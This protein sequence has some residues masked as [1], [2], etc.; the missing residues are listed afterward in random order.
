VIG[1]SKN[2]IAGSTAATHV[3]NTGEGCGMKRVGLFL[4]AMVLV[5]GLAGCKGGDSDADPVGTWAVTSD[6]N[7]DGSVGRYETHI[8]NNGTFQDT[9]GARGTWTVNKDNLTLNYTNILFVYSGT[10]DG[11]GITGTFTGNA[12]GCW[13]ATRISTVP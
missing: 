9:D 3:S 8:F 7:C 5:A 1:F 11:N 4:L 13:W 2:R 6:A 12:S 10:V